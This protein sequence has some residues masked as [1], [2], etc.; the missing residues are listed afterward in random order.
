[1]SRASPETHLVLAVSRCV[2]SVWA[3]TRQYSFALISRVTVS[4]DEAHVLCCSLDFEQLLAPSARTL[5]ATQMLL[6]CHRLPD[7]GSVA[8]LVAPGPHR[9]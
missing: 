5:R 3:R 6:S 7:V 2:V 9:W 8:V 4:P 1:M